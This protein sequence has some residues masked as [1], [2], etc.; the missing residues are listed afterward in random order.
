M[1]AVPSDKVLNPKLGLKLSDVERFYQQYGS[2]STDELVSKGVLRPGP[3]GDFIVMIDG[4]P[5]GSYKN[6]FL[7]N[8]KQFI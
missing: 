2:A 4:R 8:K 7:A 6:Y 3:N 5:K 1:N